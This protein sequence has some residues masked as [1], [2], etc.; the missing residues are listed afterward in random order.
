MHGQLDGSTAGSK[1][2]NDMIDIEQWESGWNTKMLPN[3]MKY[4]D[5][6]V[7]AKLVKWESLYE[8]ENLFR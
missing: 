6:D 8:L 3:Q 7:F 5:K 2:A 1:M 4:M